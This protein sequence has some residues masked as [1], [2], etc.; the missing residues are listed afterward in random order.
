MGIKVVKVQYFVRFKSVLDT[1][2]N[3]VFRGVLFNV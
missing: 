2:H 1:Y 3:L